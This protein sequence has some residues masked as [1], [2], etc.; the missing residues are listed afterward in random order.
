[1]SPLTNWANFYVIVGSS[2][3]ALTGLTFVVISLIAGRRI[4]E[5]RTGLNAFTTPIIVHFSAVLLVTALL[6]A[7][8]T[9]LA[10]V[11]ILLILGSVGA[12]AYSALVL[13]LLRHVVS[14]QPEWDDWLWYGVLSVVA[15]TAILVSAILLLNHATSAL[16]GIAAGLVLLLAIGIRNAWDVVTYLAF[17]QLSPPQTE[18]D[19]Q[20]PDA[21]RA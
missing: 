5:A 7:P 1:M 12:L 4:D 19:P 9:S 20:A 21:E 11:A 16:F 14:Y 18:P 8:W 15:Y 6:S 2:A 10:P 17:Q 3:G 13:W